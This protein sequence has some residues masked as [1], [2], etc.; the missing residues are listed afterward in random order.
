M[1]SA[2][3]VDLV[4]MVRRAKAR[5]PDKPKEHQSG[6]GDDQLATRGLGGYDMLHVSSW[7]NIGFEGVDFGSGAPARVM[8]HSRWG[9]PPPFPISMVY[10][11]CRGKDGV[12][13]LSVA[14]KEEHAEEFLGELATQT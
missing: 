4:G 14:V 10:P 2:G 1:A 5:L 6:A 3:L 13:V 12:N 8:Y 7:R 11:P 9:G